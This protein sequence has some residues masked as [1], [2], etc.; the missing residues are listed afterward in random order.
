MTLYTKNEVKDIINEH[1]IH[2]ICQTLEDADIKFDLCSADGKQVAV[3][4]EPV[5]CMN[6][7][8]MSIDVGG[9]VWGVLHYDLDADLAF[10]E[11]VVLTAQNVLSMAWGA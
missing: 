6:R 11:G 3:S 2:G 10:V 8:T 1:A 9:E 5:D 7:C 4:N